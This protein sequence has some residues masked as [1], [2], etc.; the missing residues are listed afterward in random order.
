MFAKLE[1]HDELLTIFTGP[2]DPAYTRTLVTSLDQYSEDIFRACVYQSQYKNKHGKANKDR[3][4]SKAKVVL[5]TYKGIPELPLFHIPAYG[6]ANTV[7]QTDRQAR[8]FRTLIKDPGSSA[9][10]FSAPELMRM[11]AESE[12]VGDKEAAETTDNLGKNPTQVISS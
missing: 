10:D 8:A 11:F 2:F 4:P 1:G 12:E 9:T 6:K 7:E 5:T 3:P